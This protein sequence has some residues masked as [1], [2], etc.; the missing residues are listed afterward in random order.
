MVRLALLAFAVWLLGTNAAVAAPR[1]YTVVMDGMKFGPV[2]A[3]LKIGDRI[4]WVNRDIFQHSATAT[5]RSFDVD[6]KPGAKAITVLKSPG[7][8]A[9]ICKYHPGMRGVLRVV[10]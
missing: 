2:P 8:I 3:A 5:D 6:L 4:I 9:F 7:S 10:R 1:S